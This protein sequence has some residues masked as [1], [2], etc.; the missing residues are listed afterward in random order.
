[1]IEKQDEQEVKSVSK[2]LESVDGLLS[3]LQREDETSSTNAF[4]DYIDDLTDS[5]LEFTE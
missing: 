3:G 5:S 4:D 1:M 2:E